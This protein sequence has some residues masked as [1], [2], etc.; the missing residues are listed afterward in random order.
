MVDPP[1]ADGT[2]GAALALLRDRGER[3][4][5]PRRT[6]LEALAVLPGHAAAEDIIAEVA[7]LDPGIHR[8]SVYRA[9]DT[10]AQ[11]GAIQHVQL[12]QGAARYHLTTARRA[13]LHMSCRRCGA[14]VDLPADI[15]DGVAARLLTERSVLLDPSQVALAGTCSR[16]LHD[17]G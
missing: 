7:R 16:C 17:D 6:V 1:D 14:V 4:T 15:L 12:G 11:S 9:L 5:R 13:H 2:V 10:L 3:M 8:A